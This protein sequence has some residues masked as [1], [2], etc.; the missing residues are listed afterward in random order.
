MEKPKPQLVI[1]AMR[2]R[3]AANRNGR[4]SPAQWFDISTDPLLVMLLLLLPLLVVF[5]GRAA[6]F[7]RGGWVIVLLV[8]IIPVLLR[9]RHYARVPVR[10]L[11][12]EG[13]GSTWGRLRFWRQQF[14][15]PDGRTMLFQRSLAPVFRVEAG[16]RYMVYYIAEHN[17]HIL[18]SIAPEDHEDADLWQPS[19]SFDWRHEKRAQM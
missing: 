13:S 7:F 2:R 3:L 11:V 17:R 16:R 18:L 14:V 19:K 8:L 12:L 10:F 6:L 4:L 5:A 9:A 1:P 15:T